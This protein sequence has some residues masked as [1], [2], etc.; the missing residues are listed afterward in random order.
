MEVFSQYNIQIY[1]STIACLLSIIIAIFP[2]QI[3]LP[4]KIKVFFSF[5]PLIINFITGGI[6]IADIYLSEGW[7]EKG[8]NQFI[9][10]TDVKSFCSHLLVSSVIAT[11]VMFFLIIFLKRTSYNDKQL[12]RYYLKLTDK[13]NDSGHIIIIGGS[14]DFL[15]LRP[16][17]NVSTNPFKC[18]KTYRRT[19]KIPKVFERLLSD[20]QCKKCCLNNEQWRQ[21]SKLISK[22]CRLQIVCTHPDNTESEAST[23]ELLGFIIKSWKRSN[24]EIKF[25]TADNDPHIRGRIIEDFSKIRHVC[26]NFKTNSGKQN[27]Y[28]A[29][30]TYSEN[31]RMG[32]FI[33]NAFKDI[34][35]SAMDMNADEEQAYIKAFEDRK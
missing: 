4:R 32:A 8:I 31:E 3:V 20:K 30:Y 21:L 1:C 35:E 13:Q 16:C 15:G 2:S 10:G 29:P 22:G 26:W 28:E 11:I 33:I 12:M 34:S 17:K 5:F 18:N 7:S 6:I 27:S 24:I 25:F 14:M 19:Y 23:K 9:E